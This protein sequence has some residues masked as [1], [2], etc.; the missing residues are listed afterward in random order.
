MALYKLQ[1][2]DI[3]CVN[4]S[5]FYLCLVANYHSDFNGPVTLLSRHIKTYNFNNIRLFVI[6]LIPVHILNC[7]YK[8]FFYPKL[9]TPELNLHFS[10]GILSAYGMALAQVVHEE[11]EPCALEY[12]GVDMMHKFNQVLDRLSIKCTEALTKQG[13]LPHQ[14]F[15]EKFL[16]MR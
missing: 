1:S 10:L 12:G 7:Q 15:H 6:V 4:F 13:F 14:I 9:K 8:P 16:H 3:G 11:Q 5:C 2:F